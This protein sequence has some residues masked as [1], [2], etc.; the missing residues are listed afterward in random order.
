MVTEIIKADYIPDYQINFEFSDGIKKIIDFTPFL[1][2][3]KNPIIKKYLY[4][5]E[6]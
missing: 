6:I 3:A 5:G 4:E 2:S 1:N